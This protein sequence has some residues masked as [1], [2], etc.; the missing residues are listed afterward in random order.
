MPIAGTR[1]RPLAARG[2]TLIELLIVVGIIGVLAAVALPG[3]LR[4]RQ[5]GDQASAIASL[6]AVSSAQ[7]VFSN[8]CAR[9]FYAPSL[10]ELGR[11]PLG[12]PTALGF[13]GPDLGASATVVKSHY[14]IAMGGTPEPTSPAACTGLGAGASVRGFQATATSMT[15][16]GRHFATNTTGTIWQSGSPFVGVPEAGAPAGG[17]AIQ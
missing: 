10:D 11:P 4:A 1:P 5:S 8:T 17:A 12:S 3:L 16:G 14:Q 2:F 13:I 7:S 9:G 6:R 15:S